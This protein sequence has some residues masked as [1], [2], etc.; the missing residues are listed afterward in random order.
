MSAGW[1]WEIATSASTTNNTYSYGDIVTQ[2]LTGNPKNELIIQST[3]NTGGETVNNLYSVIGTPNMFQGAQIAV[4]IFTRNIGGPTTPLPLQLVR[5]RQG[6]PETPIVLPVT[7]PINA[8]PLTAHVVAF[9]VP[10]LSA[11]GYD[12]NDELRFVI[13]LPLNVDFEYGFTG[14]WAQVSQS[15]TVTILEQA[16]STESAKNFWGRG[17]NTMG[18]DPQYP[19][20]G[21]PVSLG[22]GQFFIL[23]ETGTIFQGARD[24]TTYEGYAATMLPEGDVTNGVE[25]IRNKLIGQTQTNRLIDFLRANNY[26]QSKF[27]FLA[28]SATNVANRAAGNWGHRK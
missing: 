17:I 21:L 26:T 10:P 28:T 25:L 19:N 14:T 9:T 24:A 27:T 23:P 7:L 2:A 1:F 3:N 6:T 11:A 13:N 4:S 12:N 8:G 20:R 16:T 5:T 15:G 22:V 18:S